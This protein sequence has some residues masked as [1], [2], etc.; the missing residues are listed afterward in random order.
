MK[1]NGRNPSQRPTTSGSSSA[2][3]APWGRRCVAVDEFILLYL[4]LAGP[5]PAG[6]MVRIQQN[7]THL[8]FAV[9]GARVFVVTRPLWW[10][11][12]ISAH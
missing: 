1:T 10:I 8:T 7:L 9:A 12:T 2:L 11:G 4:I 6:K 5:V 3:A